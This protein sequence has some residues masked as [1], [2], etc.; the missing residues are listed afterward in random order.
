MLFCP[1]SS[2]LPFIGLLSA[3][4]RDELLCLFFFFR[5]PRTNAFVCSI[6]SFWTGFPALRGLFSPLPFAFSAGWNPADPGHSECAPST[7]RGCQQRKG[8]NQGSRAP[9]LR[10][11]SF[12]SAILPKQLWDPCHF[13]VVFHFLPLVPGWP[14]SEI[15]WDLRIHR[16]F[17]SNTQHH[18]S[19]W[20]QWKS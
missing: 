16:H 10:F 20:H 7:V 1:P 4:W 3:F 5:E 18:S 11:L 15:F 13:G 8:Q 12:H 19:R 14:F 17:A 6:N 2:L 9:V